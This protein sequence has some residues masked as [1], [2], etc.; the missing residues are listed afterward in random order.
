MSRSLRVQV[1]SLTREDLKRF[2]LSLL[3]TELDHNKMMSQKMEVKRFG[4]PG[5][6]RPG[7]NSSQFL[8]GTGRQRRQL[9]EA[10]C[11]LSIL[12]DQQRAALESLGTAARILDFEGEVKCIPFVGEAIP[13]EFYIRPQ[14]RER[15]PVRPTRPVGGRNET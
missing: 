11:G 10:G 15:V 14:K 1:R 3:G 4:C 2:G 6:F 9:P 7:A 5:I 12:T 13:V 8:T